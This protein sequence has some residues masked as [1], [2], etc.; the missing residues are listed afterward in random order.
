MTRAV[1]P[2]NEEA[3]LQ[4]LDSARRLVPTKKLPTLS[5][6]RIARQPEWHA[7]EQAAWEIG[8]SVRQALMAA[9]RLRKSASIREALVSLTEQE[10]LG[11]GRQAFFFSLSHVAAGSVA[12]RV[13]RHL[14]DP[15]VQGHALDALLKMK[16]YG[17]IQA[18]KPLL[19]SR[20]VWVRRLAKRYVEKHAEVA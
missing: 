17:Y 15:E 14:D 8:E 11:R 20:Q 5:L 6:S 12:D 2:A 1:V 3:V 16:A 9:P 13:A 18:V 10:N 4:A 19:T 7:V